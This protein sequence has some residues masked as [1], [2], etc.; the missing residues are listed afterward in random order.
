MEGVHHL[1]T[2]GQLSAF[3]DPPSRRKKTEICELCCS[4]CGALYI[5]QTG[6][7]LNTRLREHMALFRQ[8]K[9]QDSAMA[10]HC[11]E[12]R[13]DYNKVTVTLKHTSTNTIGRI[14]NKLG[15]IEIVAADS[16]T[17]LLNDMNFINVSPFLSFYC[18]YRPP[19]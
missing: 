16:R 6:R 14:M 13:H 17:V 4:E 5:R 1:T 9:P 19:S 10:T 15:E 8:N 12:N 7:L 2:V 11:L 3:K 18:N